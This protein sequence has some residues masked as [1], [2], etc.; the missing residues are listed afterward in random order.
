MSVKGY[1]VTNAGIVAAI[2]ATSLDTELKALAMVIIVVVSLVA[3]LL[4]IGEKF[5]AAIIKRIMR[6]V[7]DEII[8]LDYLKHPA[9]RIEERK[10]KGGQ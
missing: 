8:R 7:E 10:V 3:N 1:I 6:D 2:L 5:R 4:W 9:P